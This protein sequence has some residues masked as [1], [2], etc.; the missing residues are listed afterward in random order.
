[1]PDDPEALLWMYLNAL[2]E[3]IDAESDAKRFEGAPPAPEAA[4]L[5]FM[6]TQQPIPGTGTESY[7]PAG[8]PGVA[9]DPRHFE[10]AKQALERK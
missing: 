1:M 5:P 3:L 2:R 8:S 7:G 6:P 4:V 10:L 9:P